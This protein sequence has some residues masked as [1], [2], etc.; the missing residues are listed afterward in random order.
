[1]T[2]TDPDK[3]IKMLD[4]ELNA[5]RANKQ[6]K[7]GTRNAFRVWSII[8]LLAGTFAALGLLHYLASSLQRPQHATSEAPQAVE[9]R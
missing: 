5:A 4:I 6:R 7:A 1:M 3:L 8:V 2:E 9:S